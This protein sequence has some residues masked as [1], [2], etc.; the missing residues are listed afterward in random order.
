MRGEQ[1]A[2]FDYF[3]QAI[4][5]LEEVGRAHGTTA[6]VIRNNLAT[7]SSSNGAPRRAL[8]LLDEVLHDLAARD[9]GHPPPAYLVFNRGRALEL[10][11]RYR[12]ARAEYESCAQLA[13]QSKSPYVQLNCHLGLA[14][15]ARHT[16]DSDTAGQ[17]LARAASLLAP[18]E[19]ADSVTSIRLAFERGSLAVATGKLDEA[20]AQFARALASQR[21]RQ[22]TIE[23]RLGLAETELRAGNA[24]A[25]AAIARSALSAATAQQGALPHSEDTGRAWL[26]LGRALQKFG[27]DAQARDAFGKAIE[28]LSN[29]VDADHPALMQAHDLASEPAAARLAR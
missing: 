17:H 13:V 27:D 28:H 6:I 23:A 20:R 15:V 18:A 2:A 3:S 19:P 26:M 16:G 5:K 10:I 21:S 9:P 12:E 11:G 1:R 22:T 25:A 14:A 24:A 8:Q 7:M 29:T 4:R